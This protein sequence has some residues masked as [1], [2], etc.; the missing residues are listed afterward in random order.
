MSAGR[1]KDNRPRPSEGARVEG[2]AA[3]AL[4]YRAREEEMRRLAE[5]SALAQ[6]RGLYL[7]AATR[8]ALLAQLEETVLARPTPPRGP[9]GTT[10]TN[11][12][13]RR[14]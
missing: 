9:E 14:T 7:A 13:Y 5:D 12:R 6:R 4:E 10:S 1:E 8:Y 3:R 11:F 2:S